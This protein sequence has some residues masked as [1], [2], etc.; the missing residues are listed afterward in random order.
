MFSLIYIHIAK[1]S[2]I[3]GSRSRAFNQFLIT[4]GH[5]GAKKYE[6]KNRIERAFSKSI[7]TNMA[8]KSRTL[9]RDQHS[10]I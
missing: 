1:E 8:M 9:T 3:F 6:G 5:I 2:N 10:E 7:M 4:I